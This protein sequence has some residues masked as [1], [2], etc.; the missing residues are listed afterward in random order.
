MRLVRRT[1]PAVIVA[2]LFTSTASAA[3]AQAIPT[4]AGVPSGISQEQALALSARL[5]ALEQRNEELESQVADLKT[6]L[7]AGQAA[8]RE[9]AHAQ[10]TVALSNGRPTFASADGA[11]KVALRSVV[12][13]DAARYYVDPLRS[14][15]DLAS[16]TNFRRVRFGFDGTAFKDWN[17]ALWGEWGGT[18]GESPTLNQAWLEYAGWKPFDFA[19]PIRLRVGAW[20]TPAGL[21]DATS[22][23]EGLFLERPAIAEMVRG[24]AGGDGRTGV[25][26]FTRGERWYAGAVLT[27]KVV[28]SPSPAE[29]SQQ[30]GYILRFALNPLHGSDY[31]AHLGVSY[32]GI[33]EPADTTA[34]P[35][36][37]QAVRLAER[38]E[39]RVSGTR[40]V[41]TGAIDARGLSALGLEA[42]ASWK[43]LYA[44]GEWFRVDVNRRAVGAIASPFDPRF[45][46]WYLQG[47]W[48]ITGER[49]PWSSANG[50]FNGVRPARP[51]SRNG[52]GLG[53]FEVAARYSV[54][55]LNDRAGAAGS[56][57]PLG[58]VRGGEQK[59]TTLGLNWYPNSV[60]RF[61][62]DYQWVEV[63]RL[64]ATGARLDTDV[65]V[66]SLRSQFAF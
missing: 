37:T 53:A 19:D 41:D 12:Q 8:A 21:E 65:N 1:G 30:S 62:L 13:F 61:L 40:L 48:T 63:D 36:E 32:S 55:D 33:L 4:A 64:S 24:L 20:S 44:S 11:F 57:P 60:V 6:Q 46:G 10:P 17:F 7:V 27:G 2:A 42:G 5:D 23:T 66:V 25:G 31:D 49:H 28:G 43:N 3:L 9:E 34:G 47:A 39:L 54:L 18:G 52:G 22:N 29:L 51:F 45:D 26:A 15:N 50:G 38:P 14:D 35:V 58:G 59:I 56:A 16:G